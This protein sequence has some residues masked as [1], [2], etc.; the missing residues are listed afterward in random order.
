MDTQNGN[1][2]AP[3]SGP[4][5][6]P[7]NIESHSQGPQRPPGGYGPGQNL[8]QAPPPPMQI[9]GP[10]PLPPPG[11]FFNG[12]PNG[13]SLP[14]LPGLTQA[15][16]R[17][18][19]HPPLSA[20][21]QQQSSPVMQ[22]HQL[23]GTPFQ[24][25]QGPGYSL[26]AIGHAIQ[27]SPNRTASGFEAERQ[28][29][30]AEMRDLEERQRQQ[31]AMMQREH[32]RDRDMRQAVEQ[33]QSPHENHTGS[34]PLQQPVASRIPSTLHG[35]NGI[36]STSSNA[37]VGLNQ[38]A[39]PLGALLGPGNVFTNGVTAHDNVGRATMQHPGQ[40]APPQQMLFPGPANPQQPPNGAGALSQGQQPILND[41][42][43]Y[44]DQVKVRFQD[45]P[46]V[47]NKFLDIMKDFKSQAIDTPGVIDRVSTLF[48]GHP[49]LIQGFNT[50]LPPGYH[51]E[52]GAN[53]D[54]NS[55]RVTTPMGTTV[56]SMTNIPHHMNGMSNGNVMEP[57]GSSPRQNYNENGYRAM[58][59]TW[60]QQNHTNNAME[61]PF[62]PNMRPGVPSSYAQHNQ[63]RQDQ[64]SHYGPREDEIAATEAAALAHQQEQRGV[65][66]LQNAISAA[67]DD[68]HGRP[69]PMRL[70][71][72]GEPASTL[73][74]AVAGLSN[75]GMN[76]QPGSQL[77]MEKRGP[78][79][80][81]HAISYVNKIKNRF[82]PQ[83]EIYKQ[84]LEILQTYQRE[85][86][87]IQD[88]YAQVTQLFN[89]APDL[90]EDF[91]QFLPESAAQAKAQAAARQA[92]EDAAMLSNVRGDPSYI[93]GIQQNLQAHTPR[94]ETKM[95][96]IGNFAPPPSA[97]KENKKRRG[98][99]GSQV[100]IGASGSAGLDGPSNYNSRIPIQ[101]G[102]TAKRARMSS[103]VKPTT[104]DAPMTSPSL[105][106][107]LP[108][109]LPP[110]S[111]APST[112][113]E[114]AFF[115]RAKKYLGN[116]STFNEFLKLCNLFAQDLISKNDLVH[117][118][119]GF[120]GQ[121]NDL[122][123]WFKKFIIY[124][125]SDQ[126]VE[127]R[128]VQGDAKVV[129]SSCRAYGASYRL[130]PTAETTKKCSGRD[131]M[132]LSVLNDQWASHPTWASEDSGFVSHKKNQFEEGLHK[133]EEERHDYDFNIETALR[134]TQLLEP[135]VQQMKLMSEE[136]RMHYKLPA[137]LGGQSEAIYQRVIKKI[138]GRE[139]G[140]Q[141]ITDMFIRPTM[142][143]PIVLGRLKQKAE[144]W[145]A[146]QRE[147]EKI[148]RKQTMN[149]F[150]KSLDHQ[151]VNN[152]HLDK[153]QFQPKHLQTEIH[154]KHEEQKR[155]R[156]V[157]WTSTPKF[158]FE[159]AF[160]DAEVIQDAC[161]LL[162]TYLHHAH[163]S[164]VGD[165]HKVE[166][167]FKTFMPAFFGLDREVFQKR[168]S[169]IYN[170]TPPSEE[171]EDDTPAYEETA[172][173]RSRRGGANAK[174][175]TLL[176]G[177]LERGQ[178][179]KHGRKDKES[180]SA[181]ESRESTPDVTSMDEDSITPTETPSEQ[182]SRF[183]SAEHRWMNHPMN[184]TTRNRHNISVDEFYARDS[185]C[186]YANLN[187][188]CFMRLFQI[189]YER[190][191]HIKE[192]ERQVHIDI[193]RAKAFKPAFD[194]KLADKSPSDFFTDT[195]SNAN[196]YHQI[197]KQCEDIV[198]GEEDMAH[199][200]DT[201]R[202]FYMKHGYA[203]YN[204]DKML[205]AIIRF[206]VQVL[207]N[208]SKDKSNEIINLFYKNREKKETS[209][210]VEL[211]YRKAIEKLAKDGD[212]YRIVYNASTQHLTVQIFK[213]DDKTFD[214]DNM[215]AEARWSYY[216]AAYVMRDWTEGVP[217]SIRWPFLRRNVPRELET[218][219]DY[220]Q[221]YLP[222]WNED[223]LS[224]RIAANNYHLLYD[225]GTA[226]WWVHD[227]KVR[228]RGLKGAQGLRRERNKKFEE[229]F[230][231]HPAWMAGMDKSA[232]DVVLREYAE[233]LNDGNAADR[234]MTDDHQTA[235]DGKDDEVMTGT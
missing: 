154:T 76:L 161:H 11:P 159:Y 221:A 199:I 26:P 213:K 73:G 223:A 215:G 235:A 7:P 114:I 104:A 129:L 63:P 59:A 182:P 8:Q 117:K 112:T 195:S 28:Y 158:Q 123:V 138:Y 5:A 175:G 131:D 18:T 181:L 91:K 66:Q 224:I 105:V 164:N 38:L 174:R 19:A 208:D 4:G 22:H 46:D 74:Q 67:T 232:V 108:H 109:P 24:S 80:F 230:V 190:L 58:E 47:Y 147:W 227:D 50:F 23:Q 54:P 60:E 3:T 64:S 48:N 187:I 173:Q 211:D 71:P 99:A 160:D 120:I 172:V 140:G 35:P 225:P 86:K 14:A 185:F 33:Q 130:L 77:G 168:M 27:Q 40:A 68:I 65:S 146:G 39:A 148:W 55:I 184:G 201:L 189:L 212:I 21:H 25:Q 192:N 124:D 53:D 135:I 186:L 151:S 15:S 13:N 29:R 83:P 119:E 205:G 133:T 94:P 234:E 203:L 155:Q 61:G 193:Q 41:A 216:L 85:S 132:C 118:V 62:S 20:Q 122:M 115:D 169:D 152:K 197:L 44:L 6:P 42:L 210:R 17:P 220:G 149:I 78:V 95:P 219:E 12:Q 103:I 183:D 222:Q 79:E 127:N 125:G 72:G 196:Y 170:D 87:P 165:Q 89:A 177:V 101:A 206:A 37:S 233:L 157:K 150:W 153:R 171:A 1:G 97:G 10:V 126:I 209:H 166:T 43:S 163:N 180:S 116:K 51:I 178:Q 194:L 32:D 52:C 188:Y 121:N 226:D 2:W 30:E 45:H 134:T 156:Q 167:F 218:E 70:S 107:E 92:T 9:G 191:A 200:E 136:E 145:Q 229:K 143:C 57:N 106:P 84:F 102:N 139:K 176:R 96:P 228:Q 217:H 162:L 179:G 113:E 31:D 36:L 69:T 90:L 141:V 82:S 98:G 110:T 207:A 202:R 75:V 16:P 198:K 231:E 144:E 214:V 100:T 81:N 49:E 137:G 34:I 88:V 204:F 93:A 128:P 142:V 56:S 111:T